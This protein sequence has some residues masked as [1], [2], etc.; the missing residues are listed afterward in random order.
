VTRYVCSKMFTDVNIKFPYETVKN[1]CK[2]NDYQLTLEEMQELE[3]RGENIFT[4]NREYVR[5]K[6]SMLFDN[7]LPENGCDTCIHAEPNSLFRSWNRWGDCKID[8]EEILKKDN[9]NVYEFVLSSA[10]DLKCVYCAPKDS[11]SWAKELGVPI[12]RGRDEWKETVIRHFMQHLREK[13]YD[14]KQTYWFFFSGGEPTYNPE[15]L[16][17]IEEIIS[18]VPHATIVISTNGNTKSNVLERYLQAVRSNQ[19]TQWVFDCSVDSIGD[20]AEAIRYGLD[21]KRFNY[22]LKTIMRESNTRVRISPT[23]NLYA[24]PTMLEFVQHFHDL[25]LE[26]NQSTQGLFNFNMV[27]E[28]PLSPWSAPPHYAELLEPAVEYCEQ[29]NIKFGIHLRSVQRLIGSKINAKT[30]QQVESQWQYFQRM[31][32]EIDWARLFPHVPDIIEELKNE[33]PDL[34]Q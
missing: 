27:Q 4:H 24:L 18:I 23:V 22:N 15:T 16:P 20:R 12:N 28:S 11:T 30:W 9:F 7:R 6:R 14:P 8:A 5:R 25:F 10:C 31:R 33:D 13:E 29:H 21:W 1:C 3:Q 17:M 26:M 2:S 19:K 32:P 34:R